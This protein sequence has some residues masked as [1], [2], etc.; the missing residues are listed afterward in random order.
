M[1]R[2]AGFA[3]LH[4]AIPAAKSGNEFVMAFKPDK[5]NIP[6]AS[7]IIGLVASKMISR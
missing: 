3:I 2:I 1:K 4:R 6:L 5:A 7:E